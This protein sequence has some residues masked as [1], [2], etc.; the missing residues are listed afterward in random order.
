MSKIQNGGGVSGNQILT[1]TCGAKNADKA[2]K[3][4]TSNG[5]LVSCSNRGN[6][7]S[8]INKFESMQAKSSVLHEKNISKVNIAENATVVDP[9]GKK[10]KGVKAS[11][12][13]SLPTVMSEN[14]VASSNRD[15]KLSIIEQNN[16]NIMKTDKIELDTSLSKVEDDILLNEVEVN[17]PGVKDAVDGMIMHN[18]EKNE[19]IDGIKRAMDIVAKRRG[20]SKKKASTL[21][22]NFKMKDEDRKAYYK[23]SLDMLKRMKSDCSDPDKIK[24][25]NGKINTIRYIMDELAITDFPVEEQ[26]EI[27]ANV[28]W[29]TECLQVTSFLSGIGGR[30]TQKDH[31][32]LTRFIDKA[33]GM[34]TTAN[35]KSEKIKY[36]LLAAKFLN[37][38]LSSAEYMQLIIED[39]RNFRLGLYNVSE[40][41][42]C[43]KK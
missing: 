42:P 34:L 6:V 8:L 33:E 29:A 4:K 43:N 27:S 40:R 31:K 23:F 11:L 38:K 26:R 30:I 3:A 28:K 24:G 14:T 9:R 16:K 12:P 36:A 18:A 17:I 25:I 13:S 32:F 1:D 22:Q 41:L 7:K 35:K 10:D 2:D 15:S 19:K 5:R 21:S 39:I 20:E 37:K